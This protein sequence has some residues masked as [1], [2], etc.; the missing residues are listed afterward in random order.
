M[1]RLCKAEWPYIHIRNE[2]GRF[3]ARARCCNVTGVGRT[4]REAYM[5]W[6]FWYT[7]G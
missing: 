1:R 5:N 4:M 2:H 7:V 6:Q 3:V